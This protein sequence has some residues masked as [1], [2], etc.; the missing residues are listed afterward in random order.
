MTEQSSE[1]IVR[2]SPWRSRMFLVHHILERTHQGC[3]SLKAMRQVLE[4]KTEGIRNLEGEM[5]GWELCGR[6]DLSQDSGNSDN[7]KGPEDR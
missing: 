6:P 7:E 5:V 3:S 2:Q 4:G 1:S